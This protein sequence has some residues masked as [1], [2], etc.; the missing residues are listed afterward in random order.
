MIIF[1]LVYACRTESSRI[2]YRVKNKE[3]GNFSVQFPEL[4]PKEK[5]LVKVNDVIVLEDSAKGSIANPGFWRYFKYPKKIFKIQ[6]LDFYNG[7]L[8]VNKIFRD[9]LTETKQRTLI[10]SRPVPKGITK[11]N[12]KHYGFVSIEKGDREVLL[13]NDSIAFKDLWTD[14]VY[15]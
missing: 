6:F 11:K 13:V 8:K 10:I 12:W 9:T 1:L 3:N 7:I 15:Q 2:S 14:R 4:Q 5:I